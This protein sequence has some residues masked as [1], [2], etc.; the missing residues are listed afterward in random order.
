MDA[1]DF[2]RGR[3]Q[4]NDKAIENVRFISGTSSK[5]VY[6]LLSKICYSCH[7][8]IFLASLKSWLRL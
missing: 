6:I 5:S 3:R 1:A 4:Y 2:E 8:R 7:R